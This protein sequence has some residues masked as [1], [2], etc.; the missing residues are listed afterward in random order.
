M[1]R[2]VSAAAV[3]MALAAP[4]ANAQADKDD[5]RVKDDRA[6]QVRTCTEQIARAGDDK[7]AKRV[8]FLY[9]CQAHDML[10]NFQLALADCRD[11]LQFGE[12]ASTHNS[13]SIIL[14][15][16][17]RNSEA[18]NESNLAIKGNP[19]QGNYYNTRSNA[20][21]A[22]GNYNAAVNDRMKALQFGYFTP[23]GL[24]NILKRRGYYNGAL[25]GNF[26]GASKAALK[27]WTEA[28]CR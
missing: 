8:G 2:L 27:N 19:Q 26:G 28:G 14:Q 11:S 22:L 16:M 21:C 17:G 15:N 3:A 9:R 10:G 1:F 20:N 13:I 18:I 25:D 24:Q 23:K 5:C 7:Y 6:K 12:D 4:V